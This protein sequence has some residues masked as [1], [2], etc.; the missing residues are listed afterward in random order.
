MTQP[1]L[2]AGE[3]GQIQVVHILARFGQLLTPPR[4]SYRLPLFLHA[5][6]I[7]AACFE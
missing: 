1:P 7:V 3:F 4:H 2:D 6:V 5:S